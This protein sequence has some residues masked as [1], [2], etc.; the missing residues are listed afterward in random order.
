[1][2]D[3]EFPESATPPQIRLAVFD[4]DGTILDTTAAIAL[5]IQYACRKLGLPEPSTKL[6]KSV[7]GLGWRDAI[8]IVAP[9]CPPEEYPAFG[10]FYTERYRPAETEVHLFDGIR[11]LLADLRAC[12]TELAIATG[13]SRRGLERALEQTGLGEF[14]TAT[15]TADENPSKPSPAM[16][17]RL[18]LE[19]GWSVDEMVMTGDTTH[20]IVMARN[21]GCRAVAVSYGAMTAEQL[22]MAGPDAICPDVRSLRPLLMPR[23][24]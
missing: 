7:I 15:A 1:M 23:R 13:K 24:P 6:A 19:T 18:S 11:E 5:S 17:E 2:T 9:K 4:W 14:F 10:A 16:L 12:G 21:F 22:Q 20:D 3:A 8:R